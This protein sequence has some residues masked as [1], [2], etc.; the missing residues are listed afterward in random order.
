MA[1]SL[2]PT[3]GAQIHS[4]PS[5]SVDLVP[6]VETEPLSR[7]DIEI[8]CTFRDV[9]SE[10]AAGER[11]QRTAS[12]ASAKRRQTPTTQVSA[13][14]SKISRRILRQHVGGK[15][16]IHP[17]AGQ[18]GKRR[19]TRFSRLRHSPRARGRE[20]GI[21][22]RPEFAHGSH[23]VGNLSAGRSDGG[24]NHIRFNASGFSGASPA[25]D[26]PPQNACQSRLCRSESGQMR[27]RRFAQT[28][29]IGRFAGRAIVTTH[30]SSV[31]RGTDKPEARLTIRVREG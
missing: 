20:F 2:L 16:R 21:V 18:V 19:P 14:G 28:G 8:E 6:Q 1:R 31:T 7:F 3:R 9:P 27:K 25:I 22:D 29:G 26:P 23:H 4:R 11:G 17:L 15:I 10:T 13:G 24:C 12:I 5:R 30:R